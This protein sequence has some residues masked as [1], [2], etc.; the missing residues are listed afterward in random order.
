[1]VEGP[2]LLV[3]MDE[4]SEPQDFTV[5]EYESLLRRNKRLTA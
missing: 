2:I 1:V 3:R 5:N 4:N